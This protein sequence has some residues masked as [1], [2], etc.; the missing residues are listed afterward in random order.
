MSWN[1]MTDLIKDTQGF[2]FEWVGPY[3]SCILSWGFSSLV[4]IFYMLLFIAARIHLVFANQEPLC[5]WLWGVWISQRTQKQGNLWRLSSGVYFIFSYV[6]WFYLPVILLSVELPEICSSVCCLQKSTERRIFH[7][8]GQFTI[9]CL[10]WCSFFFFLPFYSK[11]EIRNKNMWMLCTLP[12]CSFLF[13][14]YCTKKEMW[15]FKHH[16]STSAFIKCHFFMC[17]K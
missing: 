10:Y 8:C 11:N 7:W 6:C 14:F 16:C 13:F 9:T 3:L 5:Q 4:E 1:E 17:I 12:G 2:R 15:H